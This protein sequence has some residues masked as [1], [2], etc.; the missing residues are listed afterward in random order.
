M[1]K[2]SQKFMVINFDVFEGETCGGFFC[3]NLISDNI[4]QE[5]LVKKIVPIF[6]HVR[7]I[8]VH[9]KQRNLS[10]T[11]RSGAISLKK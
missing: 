6:H 3:G 10:P 7:H 9:G 1:P 2:R 5:K 11:A 4:P 8:E